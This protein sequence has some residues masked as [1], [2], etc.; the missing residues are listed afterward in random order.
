MEK[1][2][3]NNGSVINKFNILFVDLQIVMTILTIIVFIL[4]L[5]NSGLKMFLQLSL[6][7]TL[8]VMAYNNQRIYKRKSATIMYIIVGS[9]LLILDLLLLLGIGV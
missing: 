1:N 5:F 6:G 3:K 7:V 2:K 4:F 8:L 9:T